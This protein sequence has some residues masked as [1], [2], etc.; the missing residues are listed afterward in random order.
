MKPTD[1]ANEFDFE[2]EIA[3]RQDALIA[4]RRAG[5]ELIIARIATLDTA[6][7]EVNGDIDKDM[8]TGLETARV[9]T[10]AI[11]DAKERLQRNVCEG[12]DKN[13]YGVAGKVIDVKSKVG[14]PGLT[15]KLEFGAGDAMQARAAD[16]DPYGDF[17]FSF[18][19]GSTAPVGSKSI[20]LLIVVLFGADTVV[21][22]QQHAV[23]PKPGAIEHLT[24]TIDCSGKLNDVLEQGKSVVESVLGDARL[25]EARVANLDAAYAAFQRMPDTALSQL[26]SLKEELSAPAP[27]SECVRNDIPGVAETPPLKTDLL[28]NSHARELHNLKN[29]KKRC[30]LDTIPA[31]HRVYFRTE[32]EAVAAGYDFCAWCYGKD[33]SRR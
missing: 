15:V 27:F 12:I 1:N 3:R 20:P 30:R 2:A 28:G 23:S 11:Q 25:V 16:T 26:R 13:A 31:D 5:N 22:R 19:P 10:Q 18:E 33:K 4:N 6:W 14:L 7:S 17:F 9:E 29:T 21:Y 32:R 8:K 24:I